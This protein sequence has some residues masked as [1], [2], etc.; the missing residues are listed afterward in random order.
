MKAGILAAGWGARLRAQGV[1]LPKPLV[2]VGGQPLIARLLQTV[3][4][5]GIDEAVCIIN[6][7]FPEV[8]QYCQERDWGMPVQCLSKS[9]A[10][11]L[12]SFLALQPYLETE[13]F[14]LFTIDAVFPHATLSSFL[15]QAQRYPEADGV[16]AVTPFVDDE[17]PLWALLDGDN[18]ILRLGPP[19]QAGGLVSAGVYFF[20]PGVFREAE[21]ARR[22][23]FTAFRQFLVHLIT[24]GYALYGYCIPKVIDVDRPAD[25]VMAEAL[26]AELREG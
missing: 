8:A 1:A 23:K 13:P 12:E 20:A 17:K 24:N 22:G 18:R 9:T 15:H 19:A 2:S 3:R 4:Q 11:S 25:I 14:L 10:H 6:A 16:L 21:A 5:A 26:L 7:A